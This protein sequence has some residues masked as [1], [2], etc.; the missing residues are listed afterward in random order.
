MGL[1][2]VQGLDVDNALKVASPKGR[3]ELNVEGTSKGKLKV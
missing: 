1:A 3:E 2:F